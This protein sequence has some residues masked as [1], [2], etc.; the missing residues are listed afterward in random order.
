[1]KEVLQSF[2]E[3]Y[4]T[5]IGLIRRRIKSIDLNIETMEI[6]R[7]TKTKVGILSIKGIAREN[8]KKVI[9]EKLKK[10]NIDGIID[11]GYIKN[12]LNENG[13]LFPRLPELYCLQ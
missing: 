12:Y 11:S 10:I 6:G 13:T 2:V 4:N 1:M 3:H 5:N 9:S 8:F 7:Y